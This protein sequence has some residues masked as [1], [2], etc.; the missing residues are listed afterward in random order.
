MNTLANNSTQ[1]ME[2][3]KEYLGVEEKMRRVVESEKWYE[4]VPKEV[5]GFQVYP[6]ESHTEEDYTIG[7]GEDTGY[8]SEEPVAEGDFPDDVGGTTA[9]TAALQLSG[10]VAVAPSPNTDADTGLDT[11]AT[12]AAAALDKEN[13]QVGKEPDVEPK[14]SLTPIIADLTNAAADDTPTLKAPWC[15][16][17][18][19]CD[20]VVSANP[21]ADGSIKVF[22]Y[23]GKGKKDKKKDDGSYTTRKTPATCIICDGRLLDVRAAY[24][25]FDACVKLNGNPNGRYWYEPLLVDD[26]LTLGG[27]TLVTRSK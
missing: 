24:E 18:A 23:G 20:G 5:K 19:E 13:E 11:E 4:G 10:N 12:G 17:A 21:H 3:F 9:S 26:V 2:T 7:A 22:E 16:V 15:A 27:H 8:V 1:S 14:G 6:E 25:H